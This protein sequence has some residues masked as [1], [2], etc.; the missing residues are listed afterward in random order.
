MKKILILAMASSMFFVSCKDDA[1]TPTPGGTGGG[2]GFITAETQQAVGFYFSGN[3]CGPCGAYGKP[4]IK[5]MSNK[6]GDKFIYVSSQLNQSASVKDP[7]NNADANA[8]AAAFGISAVPT[9]FVGGNGDQFQSV[10]GGTTMET[11]LDGFIS[12]NLAKTPQA[13]LLVKPVFENGA[14]SVAVSAEFF[15]ETDL[16]YSV[17][18]YLIEDKLMAKQASS[19]ETISEFNHI[20][21][22]KLSSNVTGDALPIGTKPKGHVDKMTFG[23]FVQS[24]WKTE[25]L[26]VVTVLWVKNAQGLVA[27]VNAVVN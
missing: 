2:S 9:M 1:V 18:C 7:F 27:A 14:V 22:M 11:T 13:N 24:S 16:E 21:R 20:L 17:G 12:T 25:N 8:M 15:A 3:W 19:G 6:Y 10:S 23:D 4:A 5:N 26:R